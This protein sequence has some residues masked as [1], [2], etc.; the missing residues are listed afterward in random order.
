MID[1]MNMKGQVYRE[2][3]NHLPGRF[4]IMKDRKLWNQLTLRGDRLPKGNFGSLLTNIRH[5]YALYGYVGVALCKD[6]ESPKNS[7]VKGKL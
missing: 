2:D 5:C 3:H 1:H 6:K 4:A 7:Q